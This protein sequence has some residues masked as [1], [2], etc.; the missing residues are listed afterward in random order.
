MP[1]GSFL[2]RMHVLKIHDAYALVEEAAPVPAEVYGS[3]VFHL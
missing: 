1:D 3:L 2:M